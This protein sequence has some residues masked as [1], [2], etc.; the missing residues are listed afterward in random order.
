MLFFVVENV[1]PKANAFC[2]YIQILCAGVNKGP[3]GPLKSKCFSCKFGDNVTLQNIHE[4]FLH[5]YAIVVTKNE[6]QT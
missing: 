1:R 4:S 5:K 3:L 6:K 2:L